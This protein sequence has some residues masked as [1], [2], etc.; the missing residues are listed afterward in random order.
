MGRLEYDR[1]AHNLHYFSQVKWVMETSLTKTLA[2]KYRT[3]VKAVYRRYSARHRGRRVLKVEV[4]RAGKPPLVAW[5]G[6]QDYVRRIPQRLDDRP[7]PIRFRGNELVKRLLAEVCEH[8]GSQDQVEVHHIR[9]LKDVKRRGRR[10]TPWWALHMATRRRKTL[11]LCHRC[12]AQT[13][14]GQLPPR[15][16]VAGEPDASKGARPVRRGADGKVPTAT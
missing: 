15:T 3:S 12:H 14:A 5:W 6:T 11:V 16:S 10:E 9:H 7:A 13:H 4:P 1:M 8:C 2:A